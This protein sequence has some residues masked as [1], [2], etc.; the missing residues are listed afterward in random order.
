MR[1][2]IIDATSA[3]GAMIDAADEH[4]AH[5]SLMH[6]FVVDVLAPLKFG[7]AWTGRVG[8]SRQ[9]QALSDLFFFYFQ[10]VYGLMHV[11]KVGK[12]EHLLPSA[13]AS[14]HVAKSVLHFSN[15][16]LSVTVH[17][18]A[19]VLSVAEPLVLIVPLPSLSA[20]THAHAITA[21]SNSVRFWH[22][23]LNSCHLQTYKQ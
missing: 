22:Q 13:A 8:E 6:S 19:A 14:L 21:L 15:V 10:T 9:N 3:I 5:L 11:K 1:A 7:H 17:V 4:S 16:N 23:M 2:T 20:R 12:H 18:P